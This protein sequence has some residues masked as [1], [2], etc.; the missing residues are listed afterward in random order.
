MAELGVSLVAVS[1][2]SGDAILNDRVRGEG[3]FRRIVN[4]LQLLA[5]NRIDSQPRV[6]IACTLA[7]E[8]Q[9]HYSKLFELARSMDII[10]IFFNKYMKVNESNLTISSA[11]GFLRE[12]DEICHVADS[13][14]DLYLYLPT[15]P[16]VADALNAKYGRIRV[17]AKES[18]CPAV[19]DAILL[20]DDG[21]VYPCSMARVEH[22][23]FGAVFDG[24]LHAA[25]QQGQ[26]QDFV[27]LRR[28]LRDNDPEI[29]VRC[30]YRSTCATR[31]TLTH[32]QTKYYLACESLERFGPAIGLNPA[33]APAGAPPDEVNFD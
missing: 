9:G 19:D 27:E 28:R 21:K 30:A 4:G 10:D 18:S 2:D 13:H 29:C 22:P 16:R 20:S 11:E 1:L 14:G 31:C 33:A 26:V 6:V 7:P 25:L 5:A 15:M 24:S 8:N 12:L 3:T 32:D 23:E 17:F